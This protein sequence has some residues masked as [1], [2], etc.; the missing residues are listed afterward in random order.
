MTTPR[1]TAPTRPINASQPSNAM[2][3]PSG[4][5]SAPRTSK[6]PNSPRAHHEPEQSADQRSARR[7]PA[8]TCFTTCRRPAPI[9]WRIA[10]SFA[11]PLARI[12]SKVDEVDRADEQEKKHAGLH[13]QKGRTDGAHVIRMERKRRR[14]KARLGHHFRLRIVLPRPRRCA[15]RSAIALRRSSRPVSSARSLRAA[16]AGMALLRS[17]LFQLRS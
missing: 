4:K 3:A 13:Q 9:D 2:C 17:A 12:R 15:R 6:Q 7:F 5:R 16:A 8:S 1:R 14:A 10:I 11:R